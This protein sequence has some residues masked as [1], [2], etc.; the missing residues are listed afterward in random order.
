[1]LP[2]FIN[3][4]NVEQHSGYG[5]HGADT[6]SRTFSLRMC[7]SM[8]A[9]RIGKGQKGGPDCKGAEEEERIQQ[10]EGQRTG[11]GPVKYVIYPMH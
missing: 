7:P 10:I 6:S 9:G 3:T 4:G 8:L 5:M 2:L 1:M 11:L